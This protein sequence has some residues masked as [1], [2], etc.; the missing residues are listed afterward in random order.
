M[1]NPQAARTGGYLGERIGDALL[2]N[3]LGSFLHF[4]VFY[5]STYYV[6]L[7]G[8]LVLGYLA[9]LLQSSRWVQSVPG[10][11]IWVPALAVVVALGLALWPNA[12]R[13]ADWDLAVLPFA[14]ILLGAFLSPALDPAQRAVVAW[15]AIPFLGYNFA[16][17]RPL[18]HIY[19]AVPAWTLLAAVPLANVKIQTA[20]R[21]RQT[22]DRES[23]I[24]NLQSPTSNL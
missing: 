24:S 1:L 6:V 4:N 13:L 16:V 21:R 19:T 15:L 14:L 8:L 7:T 9:W 22:A 10:G 23:S 12:L 18:T 3:N 20:D 17:A 2:K 5:N 11:R